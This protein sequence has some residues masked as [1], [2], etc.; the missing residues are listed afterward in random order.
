MPGH[1]WDLALDA[2]QLAAHAGRSR[3]GGLRQILSR[4]YLLQAGSTLARPVSDL[5]SDARAFDGSRLQATHRLGAPAGVLHGPG[6]AAPRR[7]GAP[8]ISE[9]EVFAI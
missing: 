3:C 1:F 7:V 5:T 8:I 6:G 4:R 2:A 9:N